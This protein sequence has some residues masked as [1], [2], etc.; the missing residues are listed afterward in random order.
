MS[1]VIVIAP[2][3]DDETL[4]CG[5]S[6]LK[7]ISQGDDVYWLIMTTMENSS[8]FSKKQSEKRSKEIH[9][10]ASNYGFKEFFNASFPSM[11]L[12]SLPK[13]NLV[14]FISNIFDNLQPDIIYAP[15]ANDVHSD[16]RVVFDSIASCT[17]SFRHPYIR[18]VRIYETLSETEFDIHPDSN[19]FKPNLWIDISSYIDKKVKIMNLY[20]SES[21]Q[22]PFPRS[23][24]N[25]R[26][27]A[28]F[29]G[30][31][32]GVHYAESFIIIKEVIK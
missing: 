14:D 12:D 11:E 28:T 25:I 2:H 21:S 7:H 9:S 16:H 32:A 26:S 1:K 29:R 31:T 19:G 5:G 15:Y 10:V 3:P 6:I 27:L 17:K 4:G 18:S 8:S 24:K 23:E 22:H 30:A 20:E 13:K